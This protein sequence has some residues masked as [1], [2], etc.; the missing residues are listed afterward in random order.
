MDGKGW[1]LRLRPVGVG[2]YT[3]GKYIDA[4]LDVSDSPGYLKV[5]DETIGIMSQIGLKYVNEEETFEAF[6]ESGYRWLKFTSVMREPKG[7]FAGGS[8]STMP[9]DLD[10]SGFII[11]AGLLIKF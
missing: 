2:Y 9:E 3:L 6:V 7:G 8:P 11:K 10:Y 4:E 5:E 1:D